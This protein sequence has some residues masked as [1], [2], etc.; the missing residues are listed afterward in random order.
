[1]ISL[2][3]RTLQHLA[4]G[5]PIDSLRLQIAVRISLDSPP[6]WE[7][8][9]VISRP[10]A[11]YSKLSLSLSTQLLLTILYGR[12]PEH[13]RLQPFLPHWPKRCPSPTELT[14]NPLASCNLLGRKARRTPPSI[15]A[16]R[17]GIFSSPRLNK[18]GV[19]IR[20]A[21]KFHPCKLHEKK[22]ALFLATDAKKQSQ[23]NQPQ[24]NK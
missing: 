4:K 1:M 11:I 6:L 12:N 10:N 3:N 2:G 14:P 21:C 22:G 24:E 19:W 17:K 13:I 8:C 20:S 9:W 16:P 5:C 18:L 15:T 7:N 23:S